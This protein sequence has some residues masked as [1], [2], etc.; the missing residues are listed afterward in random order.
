MSFSSSSPRRWVGGGGAAA[1]AVLVFLVACREPTT[2]VLT[3]TTDVSCADVATAGGVDVRVGAPS[4]VETSPSTQ[5]AAL[6]CNGGNIGSIAIVPRASNDEQV[7][8]FVAVA[9][10]ANKSI[11]QG[12]SADCNS[13][14]PGNCVIAR[15][16]LGFVPHTTLTLPIHLGVACAGVTCP[17]GQTCD[18]ND[19]QCHET[20]QCSREPQSCTVPPSADGGGTIDAGPPCARCG[21]AACIDF[22]NDLKNCGG[23]GLV[24]NGKCTGG[25]CRLVTSAADPS[26]QGCLAVGDAKVVWTAGTLNG[27]SLQSAPTIGAQAGVTLA[28]VGSYGDV[29]YG[30]GTFSAQWSAAGVSSVG[31]WGG[32]PL[33]PSSAPWTLTP[34]A[35]QLWVARSKAGE[36]CA[37]LA[38]TDG[39]ST[40][41]CP[42][43]P[44]SA[45]L[46]GKAGMVAVGKTMWAVIVGGDST[47]GRV[48]FGD[49]ATGGSFGTLSLPFARAVSVVPGSDAFFVAHDTS[50]SAAGWDT[51]AKK[52][53]LF[54]VFK[55]SDP[56]RGVRPDG[57]T[58]YFVET[59]SAPPDRIRKVT[60]SGGAIAAVATSVATG[61]LTRI[62]AVVCVDVDG[63]GVYYLDGGVPFRRPR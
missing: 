51:V 34:P 59:P 14:S 17:E 28:A 52:A 27:G 33:A 20:D 32:N 8:I 46:G 16:I 25:A 53:V 36:R 26:A 10:T 35:A 40:V 63:N 61:S 48:L 60:W 57:T 42:P 45:A 58:I 44:T 55:G 19:G 41:A 31:D 1:L 37:S 7:G 4:T 39:S 9:S 49:I 23:C 18:P 12:R 62:G 54:P 11:A 5:I 21:G 24:C 47:E 3:I 43:R 6:D 50:V 22:E 29:A 56:V 15:R 2:I 13:A 30:A 38:N